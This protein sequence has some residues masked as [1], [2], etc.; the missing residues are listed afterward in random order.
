MSG[1]SNPY[2]LLQFP[3][4]GDCSV[5]MKNPQ[6]LPPDAL[7]PEDVPLND[8][9]EALDPKAANESGYKMIS[10]LIVAWKVFE[11]FGG[12]DSLDVD[13]DADP[14]DILASIE[15]GA[16]PRLG[17]VTPENVAKLPVVVLNRI[18]EEISR[19]ANPQ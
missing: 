1:Y 8:K 5:L 13:L 19:V 18:M 2:V 4:L 16:Q 10:G 17:K 7:I 11:A 9:G 12:S 6:L 14:A 3:D 15:G